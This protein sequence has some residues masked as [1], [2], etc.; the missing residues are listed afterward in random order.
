M[1]KDEKSSY[2]QPWVIKIL[3]ILE[4]PVILA[5]LPHTATV[6]MSK[7]PFI[8]SRLYFF[9]QIWTFL[10]DKVQFAYLTIFYCLFFIKDLCV[11]G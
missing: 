7:T 5:L 4:E 3:T 10:M 1:G 2:V 6:N 8:F 9:I 11:K